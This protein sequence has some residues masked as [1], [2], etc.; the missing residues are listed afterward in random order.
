MEKNNILI[1]LE[2]RV[3]EQQ[4]VQTVPFKNLFLFLSQLLGENPWR[5]II[6]ISLLITLFL[7]L[8]FGK[9]FDEIILTIFGGL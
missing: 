3:K 2:Q 4:I 7:Q 1:K 8:V 6:P 5:I 9:V